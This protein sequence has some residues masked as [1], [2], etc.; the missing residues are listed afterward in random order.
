MQEFRD[1]EINQKILYNKG[2]LKD[3]GRAFVDASFKYNINE[4]YLISHA[5]LETG[6]GSS[7]LANGIL[8]SKVDGKDVTPRVVYNMYGIGAYD[9]C[10]EACGSETAYKNG[11]F[12]PEAAII[13]GAEY[14]SKSYV[15]NEQYAQNT[16]YK[17]RWNPE[18][19]GSHQYAT[20]IGW[21]T[22]Q[23]NTIKNLYDLIDRYTL[24]F[25][26]PQYH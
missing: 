18:L 16:L 6:N 20:D 14:I 10:P 26:V 1:Y 25:D 24:Y 23:V 12:T 5:L 4:V 13:G 22:K 15:N 17:M 9:S 8:V 21:A 11:W 7:Q 19:S 3:R 2:I